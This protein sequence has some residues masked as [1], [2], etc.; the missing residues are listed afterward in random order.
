MRVLVTGF[1]PFDNES[2]N[3][4][5]EAVKLLP[6]TLGELEITVQQLPTSFTRAA[7]RL[8]ELLVA[9]TYDFVMH[10]GQHGGVSAI[11]VER[12]AINLANARISDNDG[13][14]PKEQPVIAGAPT[15]YF[16]TLPTQAMVEAICRV[17]IP[18]QA[19]FSAGTFVCNST[20]Y[21]ALHLAATEY[22]NLKSGFIHVP[23]LPQQVVERPTVPSMPLET[24][25]TALEAA[26]RTFV[27]N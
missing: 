12:V 15:A 4:S 8:R 3:P 9:S 18:A 26:I 5:W 2:I 25:A 24:I 21:H 27:E 22:P 13:F 11:Q 23:Y 6:A 17:G 14:S 16:A 7:Q 10:V 1:D 20:M 19:S